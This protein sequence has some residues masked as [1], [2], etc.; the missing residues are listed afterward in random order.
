MHRADELAFRL[1]PAVFLRPGLNR[2]PHVA[3]QRR[4]IGSLGVAAG[5]FDDLADKPAAFFV[6]FD[7]HGDVVHDRA[8]LDGNAA[9]IRLYAPC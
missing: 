1:K 9:C 4:P 3:L 5:E 6:F 8:F 2:F 7:N